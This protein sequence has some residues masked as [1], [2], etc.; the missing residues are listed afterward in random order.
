MV[1]WQIK[2]GRFPELLNKLILIVSGYTAGAFIG[3]YTGEILYNPK[4]TIVS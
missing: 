1:G 4:G 3:R 2:L